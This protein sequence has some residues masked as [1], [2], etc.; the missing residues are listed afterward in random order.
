MRI[1][2]GLSGAIITPSVGEGVPTTEEQCKQLFAQISQIGVE[3]FL[4][5]SDYPVFSVS[6]TQAN[7]ANRLFLS[8]RDTA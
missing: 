8:E 3:W 1:F 4:F 6:K 2:F 5:A 7:L